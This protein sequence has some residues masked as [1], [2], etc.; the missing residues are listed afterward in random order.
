MTA[1]NQDIPE[2]IYNNRSS[3]L[4]LPNIQRIV[5]L[6]K[7]M[8]ESKSFNGNVHK[9]LEHVCDQQEQCDGIMKLLKEQITLKKEALQQLKEDMLELQR[10]LHLPD[11]CERFSKEPKILVKFADETEVNEYEIPFALTRFSLKM[12]ILYSDILALDSD[13]DYVSYLRSIAKVNREC[14]QEH[15]K[16]QQ[17]NKNRAR[18]AAAGDGK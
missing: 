4:A 12:S 6:S 2:L 5:S 11:A 10:Q 16:T 1:A 8:S 15:I 18:N 17:L 13:V 7:F 14:V 3:N 9:A